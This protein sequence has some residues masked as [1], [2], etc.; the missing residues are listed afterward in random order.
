[1]PSKGDREKFAAIAKTTP[2]LQTKEY[3]I[4]SPDDEP[5]YTEEALAQEVNPDRGVEAKHYANLKASELDVG[6]TPD[7]EWRYFIAV[8]QLQAGGVYNCLYT[9]NVPD[10]LET[11]IYDSNGEI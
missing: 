1:M 8:F 3:H 11:Y 2:T 4:E 5:L 6:E 7:F 9:F 10:A